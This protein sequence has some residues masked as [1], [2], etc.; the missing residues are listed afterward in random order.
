MPHDKLP[1]FW[2]LTL[3]SEIN[4]WGGEGELSLEKSPR[5]LDSCLDLSI[6]C[7]ELL[8]PLFLCIVVRLIFY[9]RFAFLFFFFYNFA[10][11]IFNWH[12]DRLCQTGSKLMRRCHLATACKWVLDWVVSYA[13]FFDNFGHFGQQDGGENVSGLSLSSLAILCG[14]APQISLPTPPPSKTMFYYCKNPVASSCMGIFFYQ[15]KVE[16]SMLFLHS[17]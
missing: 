15:T 17:S 2:F 4:C 10:Q 5:T 8:L 11:S 7:D 14:F 6:P 1:V 9:F 3:R 13:V 16:K 12:V